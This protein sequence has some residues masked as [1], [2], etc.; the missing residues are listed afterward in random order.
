MVPNYTWFGVTLGSLLPVVSAWWPQQILAMLFK[1]AN[2]HL[3][4][5]PVS[6]KRASKSFFCKHL[7]WSGKVLSATSG[8][9][10]LTSFNA[11]SFIF[12]GKSAVKMH[13]NKWHKNRLVSFVKYHPILVACMVSMMFD[14]N[15]PCPQEHLHKWE[16][17]H[18]S[19]ILI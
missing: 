17:S 6:L 1:M 3:A 14:C 16:K 9:N 10:A 11:S 15:S 18:A 2:C 19:N 4:L 7:K 13:S 5:C 12:T 8:Q